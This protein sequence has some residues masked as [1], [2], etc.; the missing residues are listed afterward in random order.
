MLGVLY[1]NSLNK[2]LFSSFG[3]ILGQI[4]Q[5]TEA[6]QFHSVAVDFFYIFPAVIVSAFHW[7]SDLARHTLSL[8]RFYW[9]KD[10]SVLHTPK[11]K[12]TKERDVYVCLLV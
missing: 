9:T 8:L 11:L 6:I 12:L 3:K 5:S 2:L 1:L 4:L 10:G 7:E